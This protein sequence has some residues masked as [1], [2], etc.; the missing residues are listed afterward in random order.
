MNIS[1]AGTL[2]IADANGQVVRITTTPRTGAG[3][4]QLW[5]VGATYGVIK[6]QSDPPHW[7]D[8]GR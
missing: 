6:L 7:S 2:K 1:W 8:D 5:Q 3:N 4:Q